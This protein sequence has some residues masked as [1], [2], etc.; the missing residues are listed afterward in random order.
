[1]V[2]GVITRTF[3][4]FMCAFYVNLRTSWE[5]SRTVRVQTFAFLTDEVSVKETRL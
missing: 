3:A 2:V 4:I 5:G 1:M